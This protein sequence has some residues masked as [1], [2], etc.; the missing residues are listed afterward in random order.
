MQIKVTEQAVKWFIDEVGVESGEQIRFYPQIY[1]SSPINESFALAFSK[2]TP[3]SQAVSTE[4][5]GILFYVE[6]TDLWFF[7]G[8]DLIVEYD[9]QKDSVEY[10]YMKA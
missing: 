6:E 8:H 3:I 4:I 9:E 1:G 7:D 2:D 5:K 10:K